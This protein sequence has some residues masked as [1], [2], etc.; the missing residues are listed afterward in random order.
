MRNKPL[1]CLSLLST[2]LWPVSSL[3]ETATPTAFIETFGKIFGEHKGVR[4]GHA[5][6]FCFSGEFQGDPALA[7]YS[8]SALFSGAVYPLNGRFSMA[9]GNPKAAENSRSPRGMAAQ[10]QLANGELQ[11]FALLSTPVFGAKDPDSFLGLLQASIPDPATGKPDGAKI[12][13]YRQAHSD[14][15]AQAQYL[16]QTAPPASY[17][18]TRYFGLHSFILTNM[19]GQ[20]Q[21]VRW[22]FE[23]VDGQQGLTSAEINAAPTEFLEQRLQQR[24]KQGPVRFRL[25]LVLATAADQLLDPSQA[26]PAER[27][28][29]NGG[30]LRINQ[31][32]GTA[33]NNLNFDPNVLATG[34]SPSADPVLQMRSA[35][36]AVSFG[37]RLSGQ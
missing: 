29:I 6:G 28:I 27:Q 4:K 3:A 22:Q 31:S 25:Q 14:T 16:S 21:A 37:K 19:D 10:I 32:G 35:A 2:L 8:N 26:W 33:C 34:I 18:T 24:L 11:H 36:Y 23:P 12:A 1:F 20:Q 7:R 17:A 9:G 13:A 5:K 15:Q 30:E